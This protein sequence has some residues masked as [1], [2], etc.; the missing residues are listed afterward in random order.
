MSDIIAHEQ[1]LKRNERLRGRSASWGPKFAR[2]LVSF[3]ITLLAAVALVFAVELIGRGSVSE[4]VRFFSETHRPAW[5]TVAL[6]AL[7]FLALDAILWRAHQSILLVAPIVLGLAWIG[8]EK[9]FYLGDPLYPTDILYARQIVELLPLMASDRPVTALVIALSTV[10][11]AAFMVFAWR[12]ARHLPRKSIGGRLLCLIVSVPILGYFASIMDY[13]SFSQMRDNLRISPMMWDQ[14]ANYAHNGFTLAFLLNV[15]MANV[16]APAGYSQYAMTSIDRATDAVYIPAQQPDIIVVMSE[17]LWDATRLPNVTIRPDPLKF[18]KSVQSGHVFS[19]E[20]GGM[21][22]NVEFEAL[23]GFSNAF[24]PYGSIP[25]QQYVRGELPSMAS[26]LRNAGY[27][28]L[29]VHPFAEW[30][31]NRGPVYEAFGF[32]RFLSQENLPPLE[33]R[34]KLASDEALTEEIIKQAEAATD[35]LFLFAVTLQGHGPYGSDRYPEPKHEVITAAGE[36]ARSSIQSFAE[37]AADADKSL[38]RLI[39]WAAKR[40]QPTVIALFGDHLPPLGPAYVATGF[41]ERN[42]AN[43]FAPADEMLVQHETPLVVWNNK[44]GRVPNIGTVSPA[45]LPFHVF[46]AAGI[47]HPYYTGFLGDLRHRYAVI[48][49]HLL[50]GADGGNAEGW[51][52]RP[53]IDPLLRQYRLLQYDTMFGRRYGQDRFFP[54]VP[55]ELVAERARRAD[56]A[57]Y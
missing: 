38:R 36:A 17:S 54:A 31:W 53:T 52:R 12:K 3:L 50:I 57:T 28:T 23:T 43:R 14:K 33:K 42:V 30:F 49:R 39:R 40:E 26:F 44:T 48:D 20:F 27:E 13:S 8:Y 16:A 7:L 25:Y 22:A 19:P 2:G 47:E 15:P 9:R 35:P 10:A 56:I 51:M 46:Q 34:G 21:T 55:P 32:D 41:M 4:V 6:F 11:A 24:L 5:T 18:V 1:S 45:F 37:G 29:A